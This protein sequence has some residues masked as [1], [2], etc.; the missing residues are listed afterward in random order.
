MRRK[1][2]KPISVFLV[3]LLLLLPT[4]C[5]QQ[6]ENKTPATTQTQHIVGSKNS[7][8]YHYP[9]CKWAKKIKHDNL[10]TFSSAEKAKSAGYKPCQTCNPPK[11]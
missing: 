3:V 9:S 7:D 5:N 10:V 1:I 4:A 8:K 11:Q 6:T 2:H